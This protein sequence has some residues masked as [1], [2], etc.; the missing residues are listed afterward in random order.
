MRGG[1]HALAG[2]LIGAALTIDSVSLI[3]IVG[4]IAAGALGAL[5]P[6][7]DH[8]QAAL[9]RKIGPLA[10]P[11]RLVKHRGILHSGVAA[12]I[13]IG[14]AAL[15]VSIY[16]TAAG[17]GY[18]SHLVLDGLT[19]QGIPLLWPSGRRFRLLGLTTGGIG[20]LVVLLGL[21]GALVA[22]FGARL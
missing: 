19:V 15:G 1:T 16:A 14:A 2:V 21:L 6:D 18:V 5:A 9:S 7:L 20:E 3:P 22:L 10:L 12:A 4:A 17:L 11:F 8:P 13:A